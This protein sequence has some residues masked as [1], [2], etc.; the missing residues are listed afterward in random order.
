MMNTGFAVRALIVM[1]LVMAGGQAHALLLTPGDPNWTSNDN[2]PLDA[3]DVAAI[4]GSE[5]TLSLLYKANVPDQDEGGPVVEEGGFTGSY[6]TEFSNTEFDP[7]DA[8]IE[9][10]L[11]SPAISCP[12]CYL[13]VKDGSQTPAQYVFDLSDWNG[14]D[15][16]QLQGFWPDQGAISHVAIWGAE[17]SSVPEPGTLA[18]LGAGLLG[19]AGLSRRRRAVG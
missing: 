16:L 8:V 7:A 12:E 17:V 19:I 15:V 5:L 2:T 6:D 4:T 1:M 14:T 3:A 10:V 11:G 18:L 9:Y 13:V